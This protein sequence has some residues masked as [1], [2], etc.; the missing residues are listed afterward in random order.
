MLRF[1]RFSLRQLV[2]GLS[3]VAI[4]LLDPL[5]L[6]SSTDDASSRWL[7]RLLANSYADDG[8]RQ[9]VVVLID[10]DYLL[11]NDTYWPLPYTEQSRLFKRLLAY[12][13]EAV[14]IDL[15]YSHDHSR[16]VPGQPPRM[17]SQ[18]LAN[19][20]ERYQ[21]QGIALLVANTGVERGTPDGANTLPQLAKASTP[22]LV[23]WSG[24]GAQY[25]L[26]VP[27]ELGALQTPAL[28]MYRR[29]C[30]S[31]TCTGLPTSADEAIRLRPMTVQWGVHQSP[32]QAKVS[33]IS[34]CHVPGL[35]D[36]LLQAIF[37]KLGN[38]AQANCAYTLTL[39]AA[40]LEV[41]DPEQQALLRQLLRGKMV[42]V[43]AR[44]AGTGDVT[45]SPLH[46]KVPGVYLHAMA[47]DNLIN[48]GMNYYR[49]TPTLAELDLLRNVSIDVI[50][51]I[52]L[53]LLALLTYLKGTLE[54][55]L[56]SSAFSGQRAL[57]R[58]GPVMAWGLVMMLLGGLSVILWRCNYTPANVLG[59]LLLSLTLFSTRIQALLDGKARSRLDFATH[60][61]QR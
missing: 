9:V 52:E 61:A 42:L 44:I 40:D 46:G 11:R 15:L 36:Q 47:L 60:G 32:L 6:A 50:D 4:A 7:N 53:L 48:W 49:S 35:F 58:I 10:D 21:Q 14:F 13:P 38:D 56:F 54:A 19:V 3:L 20:F 27:T 17:E 18:V 5:G 22:A 12:R 1:P 8:Q 16:V 43:G 26:A 2:F 30:L 33:D 28:A 23:S 41:T 29:Y 59:L 45:Q 24:Y 34:D 57:L 37:W 39:S 31:H 25:P 55:P 51:A